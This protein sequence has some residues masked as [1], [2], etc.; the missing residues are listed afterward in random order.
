MFE[1]LFKFVFEFKFIPEKF[2]IEFAW[3]LVFCADEPGLFNRFLALILLIDWFWLSE[4]LFALKLVE[5][6][7]IILVLYFELPWWN[8]FYIWSIDLDYWFWLN[9]SNNYPH[10]ILSYSPYAKVLFKNYIAFEDK[11]LEFLFR[12]WLIGIV[13]IP[14]NNYA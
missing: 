13:L 2:F 6:V 4:L 10:P 8:I 1:L 12:I 14:L 9:S 3:N 7:E 11:L 5:P